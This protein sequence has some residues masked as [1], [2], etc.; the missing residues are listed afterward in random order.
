[1]YHT[2]SSA[3][4]TCALLLSLVVLTACGGGGGGGGGGSD[5]GNSNPPPA[6]DAANRY[7]PTDAAAKWRYNNGSVELYFLAPASSNRATVHSLVYPTGGKEHFTTS[8]D[9]IGLQ[10][11]YLPSITVG[12]GIV[13]T[14]DVRFNAKAII[15]DQGWTAAYDQFPLNGTGTIDISPKYG[16]KTLTYSGWV[17]SYGEQIVSTGMQTF[18]ARKVDVQ[19]NMTVTVDGD[20][21]TVPYAVT[22]YFAKDVGV[23]RREQGGLVYS[24]SALGGSDRD[25]DGT[26]D[27]FDRFPDNPAESFDTDEDGIAD[28]ADPDRDGDGIA[29]ALDG[30]PL[31]KKEWADFDSDSIGDNADPDDDNDG[32]HDEYDAYPYNHD[33][34]ARMTLSHTDFHFA[35]GYAG[36]PS[37]A[38]RDIQ[39]FASGNAIHWS[40]SSSASWAQF[41]QSQ[42]YSIIGTVSVDGNGLA[43]GGHD[44]QITVH[45]DD[46]GD[47]QVMTVHLEVE[48]VT[49][50]GST[51][52]VALASLP[53][54]S[55]LV[56]NVLVKNSRG[57]DN[58]AW[59]ASSDQSWLTVNAGSTGMALVADPTA[60]AVNTT[61][62][63]TVTLSSSD[64]SVLTT[65]PIRV[66]FWVGNTAPAASAEVSTAYSEIVADPLRPLAYAHNGGSDIAVYNVYTRAVVA[67]IAG[68][69]PHAGRMQVS[70]DGSYLYVRDRDAGSIV[71]VD[72]DQPA[73]RS[74]LTVDGSDFAAFRASG[75]QLLATTAG[76]LFDAANSQQL[77]VDVLWNPL[78]ETLHLQ[79]MAGGEN[80]FCGIHT[81]NSASQNSTCYSAVYSGSG[82]SGF[83]QLDYRNGDAHTNARD[84]AIN[85]DGSQAFVA[86]DTSS[87]MPSKFYVYGLLSY[88]SSH[89]DGASGAANVEVG[90]DNIMVGSAGSQ[91][92]IY[93]SGYSLLKN[94]SVNGGSI[95]PRQLVISADG[96]IAVAL[97]PDRMTFLDMH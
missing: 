22:F 46:T 94:A 11:L 3:W 89:M 41:T 65:L 51:S 50:Y 31:D 8:A 60:L 92:W 5:G 97:S 13:Y 38:T 17:F 62:Y 90:Y 20:T 7:L 73:N 71:R 21:F 88:W 81:F 85:T 28:N 75:R 49:L 14:G 59:N 54:N 29:N 84:I 52:S 91:I 35:V 86:A 19:L 43:P 27:A 42:T 44:A 69:A 10:G 67:T 76:H 4:R 57:L 16:K 37:V 23:V 70:A 9:Q 93:D 40:A 1:M 79:S 53:T 77:A 95:L 74:V 61:H 55:K 12:D 96:N 36:S 32:L 18:L 72:L 82:A 6:A 25:S 30:F 63:A 34:S 80:A 33:R 15:F 2:L 66:A 24:L 87:N 47:E 45:D 64:P 78:P 56:Q 26:P 48:R 83:V 39:V 58:I 68:I